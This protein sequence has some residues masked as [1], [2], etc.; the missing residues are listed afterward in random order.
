MPDVLV[1]EPELPWGG[2]NGVL[3]VVHEELEFHDVPVF[4]IS[5]ERSRT[6]M[7]QISRFRISDFAIQPVGARQLADRVGRLADRRRKV[8]A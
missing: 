3:E 1:I 8:P 7:Y 6:A 2:G 4:A 5:A